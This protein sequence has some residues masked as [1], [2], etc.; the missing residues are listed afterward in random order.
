MTVAYDI[1]AD[2]VDIRFD[3]PKR[4]S[5]ISALISYAT[6]IRD[7]VPAGREPSQPNP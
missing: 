1:K 5:T 6:V 3:K 7:L 2:I 4:I